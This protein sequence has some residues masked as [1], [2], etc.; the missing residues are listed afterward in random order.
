[1][2]V[3]KWGLCRLLY[4]NALGNLGDAAASIFGSAGSS[5]VRVSWWSCLMGW[6]HSWPLDFE[7]LH[8]SAIG[9]GEALLVLAL[10]FCLGFFTG[11]LPIA[12]F[13]IPFV[14]FAL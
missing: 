10:T 12:L 9:A 13:C 2:E 6:R 4:L 7:R 1:M 3:V 11:F 14:C 8:V 5:C